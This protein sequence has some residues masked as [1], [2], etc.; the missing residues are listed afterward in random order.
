MLSNPLYDKPEKGKYW[1]GRRYG[2]SAVKKNHKILFIFNLF[3]FFFNNFR[4]PNNWETWFLFITFEVPQNRF[5]G[6][7]QKFIRSGVLFSH[8][9]HDTMYTIVLK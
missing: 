2:G 4:V 8:Y 1:L 7:V 6:F 9:M 3:S 5:P